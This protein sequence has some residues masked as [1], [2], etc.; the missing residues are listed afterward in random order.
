MKWDVSYTR[1]TSGETVLYSQDNEFNTTKTVVEASCEAE[2]LNIVM[3]NIK[4]IMQRNCLDVDIKDDTITVYKPSNHELIEC[5]YGFSASR[6]FILLDKNGQKYHSLIPGTIGGHKKLKIYGKLDC[7]SAKRHIA[8][9]N[10]VKHRVFF[11][12]ENTAIAAGFRPCGICMKEKYNNWK[13]LNQTT[14]NEEI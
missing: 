1:K 4:E 6:I 5:I 10:Y 14:N 7:P 11:A 2:A 8:N 3:F 13:K 9:G 12:D